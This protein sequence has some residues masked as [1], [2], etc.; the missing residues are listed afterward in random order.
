MQPLFESPKLDR[1]LKTMIRENF[2]EF[3]MGQ[4]ND[5]N[6]Y[7]MEVPNQFASADDTRVHMMHNN[8]SNETD[9]PTLMRM[10]STSDNDIEAKFS[11]EEEE[12][13]IVAN[14][15][16]EETDDDD[17]LPLSKVRLKEKPA[18]EKVQLP[19]AIS[20]SFEKYTKTKSSSTF[21]VFLNDL[22][23]CTSNLN[24]EQEAY[25]VDNMLSIM[26]STLPTETSIF[27]DSRNDE[28]MLSQSISYPY[29]SVFKVLHQHDDKN[30]KCFNNII[31]IIY[32]K[33]PSIGFMM[34]YFLKVYTRL[35]ARKNPSGNATFKSN[36]YKNYCDHIDEK[37]EVRL[38]IDL[39]MLEHESTNMF[40]WVLPDIFREFKS[41]TI[42]N[43]DILKL[44]VSCI[45]S[46]NLR[47]I[48]YNVTQGK[49]TIFKS[50]GVIECVRKSLT[51]ETFEQIFLWQI[52]QAHHVP[53]ES[54]QVSQNS[55]FTRRRHEN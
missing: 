53:I 22:R 24:A 2:R 6:F 42:N 3:C 52:L 39:E 29:F 19:A 5:A 32:D 14:V 9:K 4:Q 25:V 21:E 43:C 48:I 18:I 31:Q 10:D 33:L 1:E 47:D 55:H 23:T 16:S 38:P 15:K 45:D 30:K 41:Q 54:L 28:K 34:L 26:K 17:D 44:L 12:K 49:L 11:D 50:D 20:D 37:V 27:P 51:Y 8:F 13:E 7:P 35:L 40:L 36:I 46:R